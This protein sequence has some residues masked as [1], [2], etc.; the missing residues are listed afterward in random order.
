MCRLQ[1]HG[2]TE[3]YT[4]YI[5]NADTLRGT[6][7][8]PKFEADLF[9]ANKGGQEGEENQALYLIPTS[10]VTLTNVVRDEVLAESRFADQAHG[11]HPVLSL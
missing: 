1:E 4:P 2:Y 3:C 11:A 8:L 6:G 7:Q 9:A 5:V 10:E